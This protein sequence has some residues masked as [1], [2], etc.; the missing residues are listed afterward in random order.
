[1]QIS[2]TF[3][4]IEP[5]EALKN[6][7]TDRLSKFKR[8]LDGPVEAHVV[9]GLENSATWRMLPLTA[10]ATSSKA[11]KKTPTCTQPSIW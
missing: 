11:K 10:M 8:Y 6:Y 4:Q 9:L 7:V 2:V 3:R 1:M 5:S